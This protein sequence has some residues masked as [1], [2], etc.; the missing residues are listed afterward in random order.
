ML[1]DSSWQ[2]TINMFPLKRKGEK[3]RHSY[4]VGEGNR[5]SI[6]HSQIYLQEFKLAITLCKCCLNLYTL[7]QIASLSWG[8]YGT[9]ATG[10][11]II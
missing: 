5:G 7:L 8:L 11:Q 9:R 1:N 3:Q 6:Y 10:L 2:T 4:T